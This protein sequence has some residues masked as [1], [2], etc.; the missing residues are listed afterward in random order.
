MLLPELQQNQEYREQLF[1]FF[2]E[3]TN[4]SEENKLLQAE[5]IYYA[6]QNRMFDAAEPLWQHQ[7][8][9]RQFWLFASL[10]SKYLAPLC[11]RLFNAPCNSV[12]GERAF[13]IQNIIHSK[14][15]NSL[16]SEKVD[17]LTFIYMNSCVLSKTSNSFGLTLPPQ[18]SPYDLSEEQ[19]VQMEEVL[20]EDEEQ[21]EED[22]I[23]MDSDD[24]EGFDDGDED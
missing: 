14:L 18:C 17:K 16:K 7:E 11:C 8:D 15:R 10:S 21:R 6:T 3:Y 9:P 19:L 20:L 1:T 12:P 5:Y 24:F 2:S 13:S 23:D 4:S 22:E